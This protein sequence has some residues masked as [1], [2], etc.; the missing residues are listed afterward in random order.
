MRCAQ[1]KTGYTASN[2]HSWGDTMA[3]PKPAGILVI[4]ILQVL[5]GVWGIMSGCALLV[6]GGAL[7]AFLVGITEETSRWI[8]GLAGVFFMGLAFILIFFALLDLVLAWGIWALRRWAWWV[9]IIKAAL[10][11]V[12]PLVSLLG[13]NLSS[14]PTMLLNG[15]I[16]ILLLTA[17]VQQAMSIRPASD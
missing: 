9:T 16:L 8:G 15:I 1:M 5:D 4:V 10:S 14:I 3:K 12:L 13:G 7:A 2:D 17:E 11:I 6:G